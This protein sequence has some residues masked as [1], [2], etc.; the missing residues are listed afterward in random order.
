[1]TVLKSLFV[2]IH[3]IINA[4]SDVVFKDVFACAD[5]AMSRGARVIEWAVI[6]Q[7]SSLVVD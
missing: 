5:N 3:G 7:M 1:L 2:V 6:H 4:I